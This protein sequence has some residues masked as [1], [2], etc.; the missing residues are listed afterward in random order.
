M[1]VCHVNVPRVTHV[2][3]VMC[4][5]AQEG[6]TALLWAVFNHQTDCARLLL[7]AGAD[8]EAK[9]WVCV[10]VARLRLYQCLAWRCEYSLFVMK[11][12]I[13]R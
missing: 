4:S 8:K 2:S 7:D 12:V 11:I 13:L 6:R 1:C 5:N 10:L 3:I 9:D